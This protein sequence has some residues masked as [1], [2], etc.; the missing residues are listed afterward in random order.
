MLSIVHALV[1]YWMNGH[2]GELPR[3]LY[4]IDGGWWS[5]LFNSSSMDKLEARAAGL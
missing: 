1:T 5:A 4:K 3:R 2:I